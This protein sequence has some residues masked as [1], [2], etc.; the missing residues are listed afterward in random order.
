MQ[1]VFGSILAIS[2]LLAINFSGRIAAGQRIQ[3]ELA[4]LQGTVSAERARATA[5]RREYDYVNSDAFVE[6]WARSLEGMMVKPGEVLIIPVP[7]RQT[8]Q[9]VP[10]PFAPPP[11]SSVDSGPQNWVLWWQLFFD[12]PPPGMN[13][14]SN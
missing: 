8:P 4:V 6:R 10:T 14:T 11:E 12:S 3:A 13:I 9:P 5:L 1:I 7:G 2:L